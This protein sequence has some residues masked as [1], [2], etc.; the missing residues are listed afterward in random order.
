MKIEKELKYYKV[1]IYSPELVDDKRT[2][3][4]NWNVKIVCEA[5][6]DADPNVF[7]YHFAPENDPLEGDAFSNIASLQDMRILPVEEAV[8]LD[9]AST[10]E[11]LIPFYRRSEVAIDHYNAIDAERFIKIALYDIRMLEKEYDSIKKIE[12]GYV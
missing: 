7:V 8:E 11:N 5:L 6:E 12:N 9:Y 1:T 3:P 10:I 2:R 4:R